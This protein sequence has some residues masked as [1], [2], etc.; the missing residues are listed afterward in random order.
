M[1]A[2]LNPRLLPAIGIVNALLDLILFVITLVLTETKITKLWADGTREQAYGRALY[3][4][5][6]AKMLAA[7]LL[8]TI[9]LDGLPKIS[10]KIKLRMAIAWIPINTILYLAK[11]IVM[12]VYMVL[13]ESFLVSWDD[14]IKDYDDTDRTGYL[15]FFVL[16]TLLLAG[17][18]VYTTAVVM[19][20]I[21]H[22]RKGGQDTPDEP[23]FKKRT[24]INFTA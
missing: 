11:N 15:I 1:N 18:F 13:E 8:V 4:I 5:L 20:Y 2:L 16:I 9:H 23:S 24:A 12:W 7:G 3:G 22:A 19:A 21:Q 6:F 17:F 10:N 14:E